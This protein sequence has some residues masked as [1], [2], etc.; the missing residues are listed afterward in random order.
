M[1]FPSLRMDTG[2]PN[3]RQSCSRWRATSIARFAR[4]GNVNRN[5]ET[6]SIYH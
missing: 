2:T 4:I 1:I 3:V 6:D 5:F